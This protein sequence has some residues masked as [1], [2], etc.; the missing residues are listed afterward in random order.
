MKSISTRVKVKHKGWDYYLHDFIKHDEEMQIIFI[1]DM[2]AIYYLYDI[3]NN[4]EYINIDFI[5]VCDDDKDWYLSNINEF[6]FVARQFYYKCT[7]KIF[8][9]ENK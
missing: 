5:T 4:K 2:T 6:K 3:K 8:N 9:Y 1:S 7:G